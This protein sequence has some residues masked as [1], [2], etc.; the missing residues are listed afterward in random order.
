MIDLDSLRL[1]AK[2]QQTSFLNIVREYAQLVFL[3]YLYQQEG[4]EKIFFK[5]GTALH[6]LHGSPRYSEDLDFSAKNI[7]YCSQYEDILQEVLVSLAREGF[8]VEL[9][10]SKTTSG[11]CLADISLSVEATKF[12]IKTDVSVRAKRRLEGEVVLV[13]SILYPAFTVYAL[14]PKILVEEKLKAL[15]RRKKARD[16]YDIYFLLR[17]GFGK[18]HIADNK[19]KIITLLEHTER[20]VFS[21][22][23]AFLPLSQKQLV[24]RFPEVLRRELERLEI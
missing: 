22:L 20:I 23:Q 16:F 14:T 6:L 8:N 5:G 24:R 9:G 19:S 10:E 18:K 1:F 2:K 3:S 21:E 12:A 17:R 4:S 11:G 15:F 7:H 13:K